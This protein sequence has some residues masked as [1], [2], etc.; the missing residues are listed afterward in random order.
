MLFL[1]ILLL[2]PLEIY[3]IYF[4]GSRI[5]A[6]NTFFALL[7]GAV[8]GAGLIRAQGFYILRRLQ[9]GLSKGEMPT[10][11]V[12]HSLLMV[13]AGIL[14]IVPG[15]VSDIVALVILLPGSR[16]LLALWLRTKLYQK[17]KAG[18]FKFFGGSGMGAP[19]G[20]T[21]AQSWGASGWHP[22][23]WTRSQTSRDVSPQIIDV[24]PVSSATR[25]E[26]PEDGS[27]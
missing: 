19:G 17:M 11:A 2:P 1:L 8:F 27:N 24:T 22:A 12:I 26:P 6:M 14:L 4:V 23:Q 7:L 9:A 21:G 10:T 13:L 15:F 5:G 16:H 25:R 3:S 20:Q 18:T